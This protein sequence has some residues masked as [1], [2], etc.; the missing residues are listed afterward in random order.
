MRHDKAI[1]LIIVRVHLR[2]SANFAYQK[3]G[4]Y[5]IRLINQHVRP[6]ESPR[7]MT[8]AVDEITNLVCRDH[9]LQ[10]KG[11]LKNSLVIIKPK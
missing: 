8:I 2:Q 1:T 6:Q 5:S 4:N 3:R 11:P 9:F 10:K 7:E